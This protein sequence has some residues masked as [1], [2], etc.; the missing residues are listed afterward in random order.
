MDDARILF[1]HGADKIAV[2]SA[3]VLRPDLISEL[4]KKFGSQSVVLQLDVKR[5]DIQRRKYE[6]WSNGAREPSGYDAIEWAKEAVNLGAG[7]ILVTSIDRE[8][9]GRGFDKGLIELVSQ[10][11]A[12]PVVASGGMGHPL[13]AVDALDAGASAVASAGMLNTKAYKTLDI[14]RALR[15]A[16]YPVRAAA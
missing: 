7:E 4:A 8:G 11:V 1:D 9:T 13:H 12:V 16:G 5:T 14:R 3:A 15:E 10:A 6:P 2:N